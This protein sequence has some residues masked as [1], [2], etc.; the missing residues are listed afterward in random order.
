MLRA[1]TPSAASGLQGAGL[2]LG[3]LLGLGPPACRCSDSPEDSADEGLLDESLCAQ[4]GT[5]YIAD[6]VRT[7][8]TLSKL[9]AV[10]GGC[11]PCPKTLPRGAP[12]GARCQAYQ[13]CSTHCCSCPASGRS[14]SVAACIAGSCADTTSACDAALRQFGT[15][16]CGK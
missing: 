3:L 6:E 7:K 14:F 10:H 4:K 15:E 5:V 8:G 13:A 2:L 16:L 1:P 12:T 11:E 9:R